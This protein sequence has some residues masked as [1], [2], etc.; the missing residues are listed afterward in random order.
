[1]TLIVRKGISP[2]GTPLVALARHSLGGIDWRKCSIAGKSSTGSIFPSFKSCGIFLASFHMH[3]RTN[4]A[5]FESFE[6]GRVPLAGKGFTI[7]SNKANSA[8][9]DELGQIMPK[10]IDDTHRKM[11][12]LLPVAKSRRIIIFMNLERSF[13]LVMLLSSVSRRRTVNSSSSDVNMSTVSDSAS[14]A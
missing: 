7:C 6:S 10:T 1:M 11:D 13:T 3:L 4:S 14:S 2:Q 9:N 12:I 5:T 8:L